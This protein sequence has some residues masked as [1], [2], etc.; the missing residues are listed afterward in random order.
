LD[1][2]INRY[3]AAV[4]METAASKASTKDFN[5][6]QKELQEVI[7]LVE[8]SVSAKNPQSAKY[9]EDLV[10]DL[11]EVSDGMEDSQAF[12]SGVHYVHAYSTMYY[13]ERS[14]G[15]SNLL[16]VQAAE[17][18]NE[19]NNNNKRE[20]KRHV[21]YGYKTKEQEEGAKGAVDKQKHYVSGYL[22]S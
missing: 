2:H 3:T 17:T 19:V 20:K 11:K 15:T 9:C 18:E 5:G 12:T 4:A 8:Q 21:G 6:A 14:T 22:S 10:A 1:K 7:K 16:G 13:M